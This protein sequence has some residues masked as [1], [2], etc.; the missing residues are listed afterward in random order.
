MH[1]KRMALHS[2]LSTVLITQYIPVLAFACVA[3]VL[4]QRNQSLQDRF[5]C[6]LAGELVERQYLYVGKS[7]KSHRIC[8][9]GF[10]VRENR[11]RTSLSIC[12]G[13][14]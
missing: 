3:E 7:V 14:G 6:A 13:L 11:Y 10:A 9:L 4:F 1:R 2:K 5:S 12:K 8:W